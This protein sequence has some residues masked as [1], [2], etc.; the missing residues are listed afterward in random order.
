MRSSPNS[1]QWSSSCLGVVRI[2]AAHLP[3]EVLLVA[4]PQTVSV[5]LQSGGGMVIAVE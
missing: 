2:V 4:M 5:L 1:N 3:N